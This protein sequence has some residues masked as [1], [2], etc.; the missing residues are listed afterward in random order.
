MDC[1][2]CELG[3]DVYMLVGITLVKVLSKCLLMHK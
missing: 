2:L 1:V 3:T